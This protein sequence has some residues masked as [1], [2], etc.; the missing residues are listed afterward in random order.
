[1]AY[2]VVHLSSVPV[3]VV[4]DPLDTSELNLVEPERIHRIL[5]A[6]DGSAASARAVDYV[7]A[8]CDA[9]TPVEVRLLNVQMPIASGNVRRLVSQAV[10]EAYFHD[11][12]LAA[13]DAAK[14]ALQAAGMAFKDEILIGHAG[15]SI[16][17]ESLQRGCMRIVMGTRGRGALASVMVG[18]T[19][20][21]V[22]H[23]SMLPVTLVK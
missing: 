13:L 23:R 14:K 10:I 17:N 1:V 6:V 12:G 15:E 16:V 5:L 3:T 8:L 20:L 19:A 21:Q 18:S 7:C 4:P 22:L 11:E 9:L 2:K